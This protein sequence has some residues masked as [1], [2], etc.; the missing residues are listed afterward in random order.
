MSNIL[1]ATSIKIRLHTPPSHL[2]CWLDYLFRK[3]WKRW[4]ITIHLLHLRPGRCTYLHE[5]WAVN[6]HRAGAA[7]P[8]L[9][10]CLSAVLQGL[11][12]VKLCRKKR[13]KRGEFKSPN[14]CTG[15]MGTDSS[16]QGKYNMGRVYGV[17]FLKRWTS[18]REEYI[19]VFHCASFLLLVQWNQIPAFT[20]KSSL[21]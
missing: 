1:H 14:Q 4:T 19:F 20:F 13:E 9:L 3:K 10:P 21:D 8:A 12:R 5:W 6:A 11:I 18:I 16:S 2:R 15:W 7:I 17:R